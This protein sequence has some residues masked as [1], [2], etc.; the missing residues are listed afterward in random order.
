MIDK[1]ICLPKFEITNSVIPTSQLRKL[2][3]VTKAN[4]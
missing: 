4:F 2:E 1:V 3:L